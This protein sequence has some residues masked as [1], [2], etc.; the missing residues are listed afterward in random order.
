MRAT[1]AGGLGP[2]M[3]LPVVFETRVFLLCVVTS[4]QRKQPWM[5]Q[6][7][8]TF[9]QIRPPNQDTHN[10]TCVRKQSKRSVNWSGSLELMSQTFQGVRRVEYSSTVEVCYILGLMQKKKLT[11]QFL[12]SKQ[13]KQL[14]QGWPALSSAVNH[15]CICKR[16]C[17]LEYNSFQAGFVLNVTMSYRP[18]E[19]GRHLTIWILENYTYICIIRSTKPWSST[20]QSEPE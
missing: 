20:I 8:S 17:S 19:V 10:R 2:R 5:K 9:P 7:D 11:N 16:N 12:W 6:V 3:R 14:L 4:S 13:S 1:S 18:R 15:P